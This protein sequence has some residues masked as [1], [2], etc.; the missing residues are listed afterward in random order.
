MRL[1]LVITLFAVGCQVAPTRVGE[2]GRREFDVL[3]DKTAR[4][5]ALDEKTTVLDARS[6]FD[7]G[8]NRVEGSQHFAWDKLAESEASGEVLRDKRQAAL[9]LSLLGLEPTSKVVVVG[10]GVNGRGEEGRLAWTLLM[11][12]FQDVQVASLE[13]FRKN[14]TQ[15]PSPPPKNAAPWQPNPRDGMEISHEEFARLAT[16]PKYRLERKVHIVDVRSEREY[17]NQA[18]G[19][20]IP[21]IGA[22]NIEW[23]QFYT[24]LGRPNSKIK[25]RLKAVGIGEGD[26]VVLV[27]N[28]GVRSGAAAYALLALGFARVENY[29]GGWNRYSK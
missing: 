25:A 27:S 1:A 12:G 17:F 24:A 18:G 23:T 6:N 9:R 29:T 11:L 10:Q 7:F 15:N 22:I 8:L 13:M 21:D 16:D 20:K 3:V 28:R 4:P 2:S 26:R 14:W 5:I 19:P